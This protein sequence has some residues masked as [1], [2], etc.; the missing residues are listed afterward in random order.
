MDLV[1]SRGL[2]AGHLTVI[3]RDGRAR[4]FEG[5][6]PGPKAVVELKTPHAA[7]RT[8]AGGSLGLAEAYMDGAWDTPDLDAVLSLGV[9]NMNPAPTRTTLLT[10]LARAWHALRD[11]DIE[12]SR[13][14]ISHHYDLGND[15]YRLWLDS[16]MTYSS[17]IFSDTDDDLTAAQLRKWDRLLETLDPK[18]TDHV[19]EI[20]CGWGGFAIH[21]ARETGCH[22]TGL[23]LSAEQHAWA[24]RAVEEAG[25][26]GQ[27]DIRLQ[28]YR[29]VPEKFTHIASIEMFEAVGERW[30]PVFFRRVR[31]LLPQGGAAALQVITIE[32]PRFEDYRN[33]PDFIQRHIFPGGMLPSPERFADSASSEGLQVGEPAFF[34]PSYA[35]TLAEWRQRFE[36][37]APHVRTLGFDERFIR[38][39]RYYLAYC[40]AGF[41]GGTIDVM[42]V[43]LGG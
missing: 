16:T 39:W 27:V 3:G 40:Q 15:F 23:T 24:T 43:R 26:D 35:R 41:S 29:H 10:P 2:H 14:N 12:G 6:R 28:D 4:T 21:A 19:L 22:V 17:A 31:E 33:H 20:G 25:L 5:E 34:G 38:M 32:E 18:S 13:K 42:Q 11:N 37:A 9:A 36:A 30:W 1:L 7:R 8:V